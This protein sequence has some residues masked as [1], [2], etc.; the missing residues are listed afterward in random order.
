MLMIFC[1]LISFA[2]M[3]SLDLSHGSDFGKIFV[4]APCGIVS[5]QGK[6]GKYREDNIEMSKED[7]WIPYTTIP[8]VFLG[9]CVLRYVGVMT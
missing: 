7:V 4:L 1:V 6:Y 3:K 2:G 5:N 9:L 8:P